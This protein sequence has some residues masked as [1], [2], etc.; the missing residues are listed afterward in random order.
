M[1][2]FR[3]FDGAEL[4]K[5]LQHAGSWKRFKEILGID[6]T[7]LRGLIHQ[8]SLSLDQLQHFSPEFMESELRRIGSTSL[9]CV[10]HGC[11]ESELRRRAKGFGIDLKPLCQPIGH[12]SGTGRLGEKYFKKIRGQMISEDCFETRGH[13]C[14]FDFRDIIYGLVNVKTASRQRFGSMTRA[15]DPNHWHFNIKGWMDCDH[16][17]LVPLNSLG[18]PIRVIMFP[19]KDISAFYREA[20]SFV[21]TEGEMRNFTTSQQNDF[22]RPESEREYLLLTAMLVSH[23]LDKA[24]GVK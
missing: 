23:R 3:N 17:A 21:L 4:H 12:N 20:S 18:E 22:A 13:V 11:K 2:K 15:K 8:F 7:D 24:L 1:N 6:E 5:I 19:C 16:L 14:E 10:I 9:F